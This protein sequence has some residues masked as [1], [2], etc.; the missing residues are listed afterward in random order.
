MSEQNAASP[1]AAGDVVGGDK[2]DVGDITGSIAAIGA[3]AQVIIEGALSAAAE[4]LAQEQFEREKLAQAVARLAGDIKA[5]ATAPPA[6]RDNPYKSLLPYS[7][8]DA[9]RFFG[10]EASTRFLMGRITCPDDRCQFAVLHGASGVGKTSLVHAG[11]IPAMIEDKHLPLYVRLPPDAPASFVANIKQALLSNLHTAPNLQQAT[12]RDFLRQAA[13]LL[14]EG[15]RLLLILDQFELFFD[16]P[17][18]E[19]MAFVEAL[20]ACLDDDLLRA[21]WLLVVRSDQLGTFSTFQPA[22]AQPFA[23]TIVL[24][25]LSREEARAAIVEPARL[26]GVTVEDALV[27][28]L[29]DDL[30]GDAFDPSQLQVICYMLADRRS[31]GERD[32]TLAAYEQA[33]RADGVLRGYLDHVLERNLQPGDREI[34]WRLLAALAADHGGTATVADLTTL[35]RTYGV[36]ETDTRRVLGLLETNRLLRRGDAYELAGDSLLPRIRRW[37]AERAVLEQAREE[38]LRQFQRFRA[39]ALRGLVGGAAGFA[40]A[41]FVTFAAQVN[42]PSLLGY[43]T[44]YRTLPG[45]I[46]GLLFV[47]FVDVALASYTGPRRRLRWLV[48]GLAGA[49]AFGLAVMFHALLRSAAPGALVLAALQGALWGLVTGLGAIWVMGGEAPPWRRMPVVLIVAGIA[50]LLGELFGDA[51]AEAGPL[52]VWLAGALMPLFVLQATLLSRGGASA[53]L[54][55]H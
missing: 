32:L 10:R 49:S 24:P 28:A 3:G 20:A 18:A 33:G 27:E 16:W 47:L 13:D 26:D 54:E 37:A 36:E 55:T 48:G 39:S 50:L 53:G 45:A 11:V 5:Q 12:L 19:R 7:F 25:P 30:G 9:S 8:S 38:A 34:A 51:Y 15:K 46:A 42:N 43:I 35:M 17:Q 22:I 21:S 41:Y 52:A 4:A 1:P 23:N 6:P 14:P 44:A 40:I 31:A 2:F 29:L